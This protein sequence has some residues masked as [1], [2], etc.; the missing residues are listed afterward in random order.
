MIKILCKLKITYGHKI[1]IEF[2]SSNA[3][4][5]HDVLGDLSHVMDA[6]N[7]GIFTVTDSNS[8]M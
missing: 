5:S 7:I 4:I 2:T 3:L 6:V 8:G 1:G